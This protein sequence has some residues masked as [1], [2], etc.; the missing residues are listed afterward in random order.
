MI[1]INKSASAPALRAVISLLQTGFAESGLQVYDVVTE[2]TPLPFVV[3]RTV[4][5]VEDSTKTDYGSR[6]Q[7]E[8]SNYA[9]GKESKTVQERSSQVI[10]MLEE[11]DLDVE[12]YYVLSAELVRNDCAETDV[13]N[14]WAGSI[15]VELTL[16]EQEQAPAP[17]DP[18][19]PVD[20][21]EPAEPAEPEEESE[22]A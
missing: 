21:E 1:L 5:E 6:V 15:T 12:G 19:D 8:I 18:V 14:V 10:S 11:A 13:D 3:V 22:D 2:K 7:V 4:S 20:P 17:V 16:T 9:E